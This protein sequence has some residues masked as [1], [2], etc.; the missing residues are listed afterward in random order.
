MNLVTRDGRTYPLQKE[1]IS[2]GRAA[3]NDIQLADELASGRH[4]LLRREGYTY[5]LTDQN[6]TNGTYVNRQRVQGGHYLQPGDVIGIGRTLLKVTG[7]AS[8]GVAATVGAPEAG[9]DYAPHYPEPAP[10][11]QQPYHH[12]PP[13]HGQPQ[14]GPYYPAK[15]DKDRLTAGLLA[16]FLGGIGVHKF[17]LGQ[18]GMGAL[19]LLFSW[20]MIPAIIALI[21]GIQYLSMSEQEFQQRFG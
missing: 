18:G 4:A 8:P 16:L 7:K 14:G 13:Y 5:V 21:E 20:T 19:Y 11:Q 6:S 1:Q 15:P 10:Y 9:Y 3:G 2:I 17:Y 12:A